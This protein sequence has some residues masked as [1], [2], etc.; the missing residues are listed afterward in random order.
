MKITELFATPMAEAQMPEHEPVCEALKTLF[1]ERSASDEYRDPK[2]RGTQFGELFE[3]RFDLFKWTE[4][5]VVHLARF[6]HSALSSLIRKVTSYDRERLASLRFDYHAWFH[7]TRKGGYQTLHNHQNASWSGIFCVDPGDMVEDRP[8]SGLVRFHDPRFCSWFYSDAGNL[9]LEMPWTHGGY[10][11]T[12]RPGRLVLF[13]S[14][15]MHEILP[16]V[17]E[18][19]RIVVAFNCSVN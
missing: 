14:F 13:P 9:G 3:S 12:H 5:P 10:D 15:L 19:P 18:R 6:C 4:E 1:L 11:V 8:D 2:R 17:G 16:Y 7:V